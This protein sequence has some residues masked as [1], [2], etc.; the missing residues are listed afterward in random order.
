MDQ[1]H[2]VQI[3][4]P[5]SS[6]IMCEAHAI[7]HHGAL[8]NDVAPVGLIDLLEGSVMWADGPDA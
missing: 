7:N 1:L 5:N 2:G 6:F 4:C 8:W 3:R